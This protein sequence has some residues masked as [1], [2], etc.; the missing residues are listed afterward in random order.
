MQFTGIPVAEINS[1]T[2]AHLRKPLEKSK[3]NLPKDA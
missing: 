2:P 1:F 3:L